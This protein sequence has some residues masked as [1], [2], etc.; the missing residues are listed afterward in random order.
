M[1]SP[2]FQVLAC[3]F[4][5]GCTEKLS[6]E[7]SITA[8]GFGTG[9]SAASLS[10]LDGK[11]VV[12]RD[13]SAMLDLQSGDLE[14]DFLVINVEGVAVDLGEGDF[15]MVLTGFQ[16]VPESAIFIDLD[17]ECVS[18]EVDAGCTGLWESLELDSQEMFFEFA[19]L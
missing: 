7:W 4:L 3:L 13:G 17:L 11:L 15:S 10:D 2:V 18:T 14:G 9:A 1:S 8:A 5:M 12:E 16:E 6:G 19:L